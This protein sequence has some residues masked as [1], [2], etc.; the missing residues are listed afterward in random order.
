MISIDN[1]HYNLLRSQYLLITFNTK[2]FIYYVLIF[3]LFFC[4]SYFYSFYFFCTGGFLEKILN[5]KIKTN[6]NIFTYLNQ[7]FKNITQVEKIKYYF[8]TKLIKMLW[9]KKMA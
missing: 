4:K 2:I 9:I 6:K 5:R 7:K 3:C 8:I 1:F